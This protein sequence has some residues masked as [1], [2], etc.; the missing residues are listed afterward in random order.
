MQFAFVV[1]AFFVLS[2]N[3]VS[4]PLSTQAALANP[5]IDYN[6]IALAG[7][8]RDINPYIPVLTDLNAD[9]VQDQVLSAVVGS[10][11]TYVP[12][13]MLVE[14]I[15]HRTADRIRRG[16]RKETVTHTVAQGETLTKIAAYYGINVA[17]IVE[18]NNLDV[19]AVNKLKAGTT[20]AI[21]PEKTSDSLDWLDKLHEEERLA[22]EK[23]ENE[24]RAKLARS[25]TK[26]NIARAA[27]TSND[28]GGSSGQFRKPFGYGCYNGYHWWAIDCPADIGSGVAASAS[29]VVE[30]ADANGYNGGY[31]KT[32]VINH[33]NGWETRYAHL[34]ALNVE[35]GQR[36]STGQIIAASGNTGH[37][38]GPHLHFEITK[39]GQ[40]LN[41]GNYVGY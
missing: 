7:A 29:G 37:S 12:K 41:P 19:A 13:P 6:P 18:E 21:A 33:G 8:S 3:A 14:T 28:N 5:L 40:R 36:V 27:D 10:E 15:D 22:R 20:L 9:E 11:S 38:T 31:G 26:V 39:N 35:P 4:T 2:L 30:V 25:G 17:T 16:L 34:S 1:I 24:Q 32:I 23:R